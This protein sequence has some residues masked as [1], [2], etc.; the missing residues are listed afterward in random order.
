VN[1]QVVKKLIVTAIF[2]WL[3]AAISIFLID[4][5]AGEEA[6]SGVAAMLLLGS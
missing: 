2:V 3:L 4:L 1:A 6:E 5:L